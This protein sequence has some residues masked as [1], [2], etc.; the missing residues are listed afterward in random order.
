[1]TAEQL[2]MKP[3]QSI[4]LVQRLI[5]LMILQNVQNTDTETGNI[6]SAV[7]SG[8]LRELRELLTVYC[9]YSFVTPTN[10]VVCRH[11]F[12]FYSIKEKLTRYF[13]VSVSI[14]I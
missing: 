13:L 8:I 10:D 5:A 1:M 3:A 2:E 4:S 9:F 6:G 14:I 12:T 7:N 11:A